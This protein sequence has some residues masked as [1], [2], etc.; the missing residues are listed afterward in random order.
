MTT[1]IKNN[2]FPTV[3]ND[4]F[5]LGFEKVFTDDFG[6]KNLLQQ[7]PVNIVETPEAF[8][9]QVLAP[10]KVKENFGLSMEKNLLTI[11]YH[12]PEAASTNEVKYVRKEFSIANFKRTF[13]VSDTVDATKIDATYTNGI[14]EIVLPKKEETVL[15]PTTISIK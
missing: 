2:H 4:L 9:L 1:T 3:L 13:T 15:Q 8:T 11:S 10:G 6:T 5:N 14:L 7:P 12:T